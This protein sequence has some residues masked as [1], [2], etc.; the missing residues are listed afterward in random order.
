MQKSIFLFLISL[1]PFSGFTG[2][3][4]RDYIDVIPDYPKPGIQFQW[5]GPVMRNPEAFERLTQEFAEHYRGQKIDAILGLEARGFIF[6]AALARELGVGFIPVRKSGKLPGETIKSCYEKEYGHDCFEI[7]SK[8]LSQG[9]RVII[10]DDLIATGGTA[11]AA[12]D[13]AS[14]LGAE[15]VEVAC[16]IELPFLKGREKLPCPLF[17]LLEV[18]VEE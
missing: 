17:T 3:W 1:I 15:V 14:R 7:E 11:L 12:C 6:G 8:C 13:L 5:L 18:H 2:E 16:V 10:I 4:I 9:S